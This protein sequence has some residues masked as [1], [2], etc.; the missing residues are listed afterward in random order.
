VVGVFAGGDIRASAT[1]ELN[2]Q[3]SVKDEI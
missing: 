2:V 1:V 3:N